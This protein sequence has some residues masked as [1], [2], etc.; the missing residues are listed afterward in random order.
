MSKM[1]KMWKDIPCSTYKVSDAGDVASERRILKPYVNLEG[2][3]TVTLYL[4][5]KGFIIRKQKYVSALVAEAFLPKPKSKEK[6]IISHLNKDRSDNRVKNLCWMTEQEN[7][8]IFKGK[9]SSVWKKA[10]LTKEQVEMI[11]SGFYSVAELMS[12]LE[13]SQKTIT[14]VRD[15]KTHKII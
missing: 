7:R 1:S 3:K 8:N 12:M 15:N 14:N 5:I 13:V 2:I 4:T 9:K 11:R 6:L 10:K